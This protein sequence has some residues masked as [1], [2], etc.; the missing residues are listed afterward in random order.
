MARQGVPMG[1]PGQAQDVA[2][3]VLFLSSDA[4]RY[5]RRYH[6]RQRQA[7]LIETQ[8]RIPEPIRTTSINGRK[9]AGRAV[10]GCKAERPL[11]D[12]KAARGY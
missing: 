7:P 5:R 2:D 11:S 9:G 6:G 1:Q 12:S 10:P 3:G 4:S 8:T